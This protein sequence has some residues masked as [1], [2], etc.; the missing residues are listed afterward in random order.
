MVEEHISLV[1]EPG[2]KYIGHVTSSSGSA[3]DICS[4]ILS[5]LHENG[6]DLSRIKV[7]GAA[8]TS[9]NTDHIGCVNTLIGK[10]LGHSL[11]WQICLLYFNELPLR[12]LITNLDGSTTGSASFSGPIGNKMKTCERKPVVKFKKIV[13]DLPDIDPECLSTDQNTSWK[14]AKLFAAALIQIILRI[15]IQ[16]RFAVLSSSL[17]RIGFFVYTYLNAIPQKTYKFWQSI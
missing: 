10:H 3:V 15:E 16:V 4:S 6:Y 12:H 8:G 13:V 9:V 14:C 11:Q 5:Y 17:L 2:S 1:S 7:I